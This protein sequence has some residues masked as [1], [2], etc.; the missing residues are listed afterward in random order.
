MSD[1]T[2][3]VS[4]EVFNEVY[5][6]H[7][8]NTARV[9]IYFGGSSSGKSVF[10]AQ[11]CV[12]DVMRGHRNYL[13]CRQVARTLRMSV[14]SEICAVIGAWDAGDLFNINKSD[15][16]ITCINGRQIAFV[17]LDDVEKLKSIRPA[18]GAWT[19]VWIEEATET[20]RNSIKQLMK[21]QRGGDPDTKKRMTL[22]FNPILQN[23]W[24][25]E[26]YFSG[27]GWANEQTIHRDDEL[28]ILKTIYKDNKFLTPGDVADLESETDPYYRNVYT[29][30]NWG[31]L[32]NVIFTNWRVE[33]LAA[34]QA[35]FTN[36]RNGLDF[37]FSSDPAALT[38]SHY[39]RMHK[40]IYIFDEIYETGLTNPVL[41][42]LLVEMCGQDV[43]TCDS[44]EPKSIQELKDHGVKAVAAR[45]GQD[46]VSF[47]IQWLQQQSIIVDTNCINTRN[48]LQQYK[49]KEDKNGNAIRQPVDRN[50]H[51]ID[52]LRYAYETD[53]KGEPRQARARQ[54]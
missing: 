25:Y 19:D 23:H 35:Q 54:G 21:R 14:F 38:R 26:E 5:L 20:E 43:I 7:L 3:D 32:G 39:D 48:E 10:I 49:W 53:G 44:A 45:K 2:I 6:P 33:D 24:I 29:L 16:V 22:T 1:I 18:V 47:G 9:Q 52:A 4:P 31:V 12:F 8:K 15:M 34:M 46:S 42:G 37:G 41:A 51:I 11:R 28:S 40:T 27:I 17:G 36:H 30:G 13:I 50:N